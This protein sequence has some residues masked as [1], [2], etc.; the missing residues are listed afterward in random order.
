MCG[1][2]DMSVQERLLRKDGDT[3]GKLTAVLFTD[4]IKILE[5]Q[6]IELGC[7]VHRK[8][9]KAHKEQWILHSAGEGKCIHSLWGKEQWRQIEAFCTQGD[10]K[11]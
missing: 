5:R 8:Q 7:I 4:S 1:N 10:I 3:R 2:Q 9:E 11:S 6:I